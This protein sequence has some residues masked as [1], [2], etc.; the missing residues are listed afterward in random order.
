MTR[1]PGSAL[2]R[3][4]ARLEALTARL[5][6]HEADSRRALDAAQAAW[7]VP[8]RRGDWGPDWQR[9]QRRIDAGET[10]LAAAFRGAD[11]D[12][13][14]LRLLAV[15]RTTIAALA[16]ELPDDLRDGAAS[17]DAQWQELRARGREHERSGRDAT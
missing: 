9:L 5:A 17:A 6:A 4:R 7:A 2:D 1:V 13:A 14:S 10:T 15:S 11:G 12:E 3:H 16:A 8:A